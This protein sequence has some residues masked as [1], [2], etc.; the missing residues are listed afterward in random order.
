MGMLEDLNNPEFKEINDKFRSGVKNAADQF[1]KSELTI[2]LE[3]RYKND[4]EKDSLYIEVEVE[5]YMDRRNKKQTS[6]YRGFL[7]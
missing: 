5:V 7:G 4:P 2:F 6:Y 3:E 1:L